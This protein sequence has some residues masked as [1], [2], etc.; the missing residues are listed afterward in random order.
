MPG[1][2]CGNGGSLFEGGAKVRLALCEART[3]QQGALLRCK[4]TTFAGLNSPLGVGPTNSLVPS[5]IA[6]FTSNPPKIG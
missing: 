1:R 5:A 6:P 3:K 2:R 4:L